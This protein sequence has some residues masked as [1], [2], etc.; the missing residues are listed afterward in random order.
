M[1]DFATRLRE[2]R[3]GRSLRQKDLAVALGL[4]Q[5]TIANYE[6][7]LRFPD[8]PTLVKIADFF[9]VSLDELMGRSEGQVATAVASDATGLTVPPRSTGVEVFP[10][11]AREFYHLLREKGPDAARSRLREVL[12]SGAPIADVYLGILTPAL[13]EVGR[14]WAIGEMSVAD[15]HYFSEATQQIMASLLPHPPARSTPILR[16]VVL[17]VSGESHLIG[18]RMVGDLLTLSGVE[19]RFLGAHLSIGHVRETL[20]AS[21]PDLVALSVTLPE[22]VNTAADTI[23]ALREKRTLSHTRVMVGG[24]AFESQP[25]LWK[26][27]GADAQ[28]N[29]AA[30]AVSTALRLSAEKD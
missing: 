29:D 27:I 6:Q 26:R 23:R 18:A 8:E 30:D 17:P 1:S 15:E 13:R 16:C 7:K 9:S 25:T 24:Q 20:L 3:M 21:P 19:V 5:T 2:L 4:A 10:A 14:L 11:P 12:E 28:A 22:F